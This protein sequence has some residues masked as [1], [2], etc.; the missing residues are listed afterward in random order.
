[1]L[2][3]ELVQDAGLRLDL[4]TAN[5]AT[6]SGLRSR[7]LLFARESLDDVASVLIFEFQRF[8]TAVFCVTAQNIEHILW[9]EVRV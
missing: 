7:A 2:A 8:L 1:M 9:L 6:D 3:L 4:E 5:E